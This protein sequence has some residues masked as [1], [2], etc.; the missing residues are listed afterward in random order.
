[1]KIIYKIIK[2]LDLK[3][4]HFYHFLSETCQD[5]VTVSCLCEYLFNLYLSYIFQEGATAADLA[6]DAGYDIIAEFLKQSS[7]PP[8]FQTTV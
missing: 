2:I 6:R 5:F 8:S 7:Q 3:R 1:M 4:A